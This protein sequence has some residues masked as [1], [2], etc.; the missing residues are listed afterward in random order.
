[1]K[2]KL[3]LLAAA[4][5]VSPLFAIA[6]AP[7]PALGINVHPAN[8]TP[9]AAAFSGGMSC[10]GGANF[11]NTI[12][13]GQPA[14]LLATIT[15]AAEHV[16]TQGSLYMVAALGAYSYMLTPAGFTIW[17]GNPDELV[18]ALIPSLI[19]L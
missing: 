9:P 5:A 6:Q 19:S 13:A 2:M 18:R 10:N 11:V 1:M 8:A 3:S 17:N 14:G 4:I 15:P 16:G 12:P 7:Q